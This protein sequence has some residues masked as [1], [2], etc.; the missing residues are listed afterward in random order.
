MIIRFSAPSKTF[1][2]GEYAVLSGG[3]ALVINSEPRFSLIAKPGA[4]ER[5]GIHAD[6]P[7]GKWISRQSALLGDWDLEFVDPHAGRGGFGASSAQFLFVHAL[8]TFLQ[9][10][11]SRAME[12]LNMNALLEDYK[13]MAM[14]PASGADVLAQAAGGIARVAAGSASA[15]A[16][17]YADLDFAVI[18]TGKKINTHEHLAQ[19]SLEPLRALVAPATAVVEKFGSDEFLRT[20]QMFSLQLRELG[21][22]APET[23]ALLS[24]IEAQPWCKVAKGCGALGADTVLVIFARKD[25][26]EVFDFFSRCGLEIVADSSRESAGLEMN[27]SLA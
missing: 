21:L 14:E 6:S 7:A 23:L 26:P 1:L 22:Q 2:A 18:R 16:W 8:A 27:W 17:P 19:L 3:P 13:S 12:G 20:L 4:G 10:S 15:L 11:V 9:I 5:H 24:Q 25:K